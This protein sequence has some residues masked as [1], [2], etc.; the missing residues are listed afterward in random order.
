TRWLR[1]AS[2]RSGPAQT[3]S[4]GNARGFLP[5]GTPSAEELSRPAGDP[6]NGGRGIVRRRTY[7]VHRPERLGGWDPT[8]R[9]AFPKHVLAGPPVSQRLQA[10]TPTSGLDERVVGLVIG[11]AIAACAGL[12]LSGRGLI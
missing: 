4:S 7:R 12:M 10:A 5:V 6:S 3:T 1:R 11:L 2:Y 9:L 8:M